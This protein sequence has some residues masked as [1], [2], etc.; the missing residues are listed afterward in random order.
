[1]RKVLAN[2]LIFIGDMFAIW[3]IGGEYEYKD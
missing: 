2:T 1:M 3:K